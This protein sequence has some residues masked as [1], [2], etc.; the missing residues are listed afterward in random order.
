MS[1]GDS[2]KLVGLVL[3]FRHVA[4]TSRMRGGCSPA[5]NMRPYSDKF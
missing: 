1:S 4:G 3:V 2:Q 5:K